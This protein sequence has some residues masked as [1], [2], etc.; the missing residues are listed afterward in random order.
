MATPIKKP[1]VEFYFLLVALMVIYL[2]ARGKFS[3]LATVLK[4]PTANTGVVTSPGYVIDT[5][6]GQQK[7]LT[8]GVVPIPIPGIRTPEG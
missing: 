8:G 1:P 6:T 3:R 4:T 2:A 7:S 5:R